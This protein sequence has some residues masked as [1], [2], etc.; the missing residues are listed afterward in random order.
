MSAAPQSVLRGKL[1]STSD[2]I[3]DD[4]LVQRDVDGAARYFCRHCD[5]D[6]AGAGPDW[7]DSLRTVYEGPPSTVG[8]HLND[9]ARKYVDVDIVVRQGYC[10]G[11]FTALFTETAPRESQPR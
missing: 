6:I 3:I 1:V 8:P 10:P 7:R 5:T 9:N 2:Q 4:N 11:C